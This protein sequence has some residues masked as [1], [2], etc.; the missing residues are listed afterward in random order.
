VRGLFPKLESLSLMYLSS[1]CGAGLFTSI[2]VLV[3]YGLL[4]FAE[5]I[6]HETA[7]IPQINEIFFFFVYTF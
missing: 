6:V 2:S 7:F 1:C 5:T 4:S 3:R